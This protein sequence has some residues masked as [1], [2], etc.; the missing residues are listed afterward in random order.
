MTIED[1]PEVARV[2][3]RCFSNPW[4]TSAYR[5]E[6]QAPNQNHYLVL[7]AEQPRLPT[8]EVPAP[9]T[10]AGPQPGSGPLRALPRR[11]LLPLTRRLHGNDGQRVEPILGF[12][13]M[14]IMYDE[15]HVTTIGV[16]PDHRG[17]GLG[18]LLLV[19]AFDEAVRR[20][21]QWLTLEV[22][23]S[24]EPA[25]ALYRKYGFSGQ[26]TRRRYYSDN[27]EDALI[28]WS[29]PLADAAY[30]SDVAELRRDLFAKLGHLPSGIDS[31]LS[32]TA[33]PR[34]HSAAS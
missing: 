25:Q 18:E 34:L 13:G 4:P 10:P 21:A 15:A 32:A 3:R 22:R 23:M 6:L 28:M 12:V 11:T 24:N 1:I 29:R 16:D 2:E 9:R 7:R 14:W 26:G 17:R 31:E 8:P 30:Q 33:Q 19:A 27:N 5:R 20:R